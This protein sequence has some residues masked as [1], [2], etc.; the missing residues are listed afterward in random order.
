MTLYESKYGV[1]TQPDES[2]YLIGNYQIVAVADMW[3]LSPIEMPTSKTWLTSPVMFAS[4]DDAFRVGIVFS[5]EDSL[6][7]GIKDMLFAS[8]HRRNPDA[9]RIPNIGEQL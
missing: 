6:A 5:K 1:I 2:T 7:L 9:V 8:L 3:E 4:L